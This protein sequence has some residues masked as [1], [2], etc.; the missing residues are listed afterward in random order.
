MPSVDQSVQAAR[1]TGAQESNAMVRFSRMKDHL[2]FIPGMDS[3]SDK[4]HGGAKRGLLALL[5]KSWTSTT[6]VASQSLFRR[7]KMHWL[8]FASIGRLLVS[9]APFDVRHHSPA[10]RLGQITLSY[11][12]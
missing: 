6:L 9:T 7:R 5:H 1:K 10:V 11:R 4:G 12:V 2:H 3:G 8:R